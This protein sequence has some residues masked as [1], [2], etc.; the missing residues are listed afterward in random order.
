MCSVSLT[1]GV[2][3][4]NAKDGLVSSKTN[5]TGGVTSTL[6]ITE[7]GEN[8]NQLKCV[9]SGSIAIEESGAYDIRGNNLNVLADL[10]EDAD[11]VINS[12]GSNSAFCLKGGTV[13]Q[14]FSDDSNNNETYIYAYDTSYVL[15]NNGSYNTVF[16]NAQ[17]AMVYTGEESRNNT[18]T[19]CGNTNDIYI[20]GYNN[21]YISRGNSVINIGAVAEQTKI[22]GSE[23][24]SDIVNDKAGS[25]GKTDGKTYYIGRNSNGS[26]KLNLFGLNALAD[27]RNILSNESNF[28]GSNNKVF[29]QDFYQD[30]LGN[31][32]NIESIL[33]QY[34]WT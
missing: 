33:Y 18:I 32:Y 31:M 2:V 6:G 26:V 34:G 12:E 19:G 7:A 17:Q 27:I 23:T 15:L 1:N 21:E 9:K 29:A 5:V 28:Y 3:S 25:T 24:G 10:D 20:S 8:V 13:A 30:S 11:L 22:Q 4:V 16:S 14:S